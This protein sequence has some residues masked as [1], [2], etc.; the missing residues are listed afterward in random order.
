MNEKIKEYWSFIF[1]VEIISD[2]TKNEEHFKKHS[3]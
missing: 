1:Y 3:G 2:K